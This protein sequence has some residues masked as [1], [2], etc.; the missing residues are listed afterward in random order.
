MKRNQVNKILINQ[1]KR[2]NTVCALVVVTCIVFLISV[3]FFLLYVKGGENKY[4]SYDER[5]TVDY[6]VNLKDNDFFDDK[7]L[8]KDSQYIASLI[9]NI[10]AAF[11]YKLSLDEDDVEYRY[12]YRIDATVDVKKK[13]A[14][15]SLY[16]TTKELLSEKEYV[17]DDAEVNINQKINIDY[18]YYNNL[19]N[20]FVTIY[21]IDNYESTLDVT[22]F[23]KVIGSCEDFTDEGT[24]ESMV[25]L[26]IPLTEKTMGIELGNNILNTNNNLLRCKENGYGTYLALFMSIVGVVFAV[27]LVIYTIRFEIKTRTAEDIY[28]RELKQIL[29]NYSSY[30]QTL[31]CEFDFKGYQKLKINAFN[32]MLE[33]SERIMQPILMREN[34]DKK[35]CY[36]LIP[37]STKI[38]YVYRLDVSDVVV[39]D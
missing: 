36:F 14:N 5:G 11:N 22:L 28:E 18:N 20:K 21:D 15:Y 7:Y 29:N 6:K 37:S 12:S 10:E 33:I 26:S 1:T 23:V 32:D 19:I 3:G 2:R 25:S 16:T 9:N 8:G 35:S 24:K 13:D 27:I 31:D 38:L 4:V 39:E 30:I 34:T 17:T